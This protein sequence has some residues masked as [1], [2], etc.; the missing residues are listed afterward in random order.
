[1]DAALMIRVSAIRGYS[2]PT[3]D[4]VDNQGRHPLMITVVSLHPTGGQG[5][6]VNRGKAVPQELYEGN[7][8]P[9]DEGNLNGPD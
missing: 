3:F 6:V 4:G 5:V 9:R 1:M 2:R 7:A 8:V